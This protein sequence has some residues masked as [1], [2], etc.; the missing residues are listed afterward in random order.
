MSD[1]RALLVDCRVA[2]RGSAV[3]G[4]QSLLQRIE[5]AIAEVGKPGAASSAPGQV[6][7]SQTA[8]QVALAW[9]TVARG[10]KHTYPNVYDDLSERV[11]ALL[12]VRTLHEPTE[13]LLALEKRTEALEKERDRLASRLEQSQ[14]RQRMLQTQLDDLHKAL[15]AAV[16]EGMGSD[17][18]A[19]A[20]NRLELLLEKISA[21][22]PEGGGATPSAAA[23]R[24]DGNVPNRQRLEKVADGDASFTKE[25]R[26]WVLGE[27][28]NLT[29][30]EFTPVELIEKGDQWLAV[31]LLERGS[32]A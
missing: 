30:W 26:D 3:Q 28:L 29:G 19:Q 21:P 12:D 16:P 17:A 15:A 25:Q 7:L 8:Q 2:L 18:H 27:A 20:L 6:S 11:M 10:L 5:V 14:E 23:V 24:E 22:P 13:E 1:L 9:Q 31:L 4:T 32:L